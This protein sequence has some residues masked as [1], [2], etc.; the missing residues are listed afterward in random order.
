MY[1]SGPSEFLYLEKNALL[2]ATDSFHACVFSIIFSTP[3]IVFKRDDNKLESMHSRIETLLKTFKMENRIFN[4]TIGKEILNSD[5]EEA[6]KT[7]EKERIRA[8]EFLKKS[9]I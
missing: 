7:L 4:G 5:Y 2:V 3:F 1:I 6:H 9:L 8:N